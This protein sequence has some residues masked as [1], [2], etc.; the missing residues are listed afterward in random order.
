MDLNIADRDDSD[1]S[2]VTME[3]STSSDVW[4]MDSACSYHMGPNRDWFVDL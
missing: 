1:F 3:P 2:L 4:L